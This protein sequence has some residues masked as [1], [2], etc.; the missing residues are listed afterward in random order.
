MFDFLVHGF[1]DLIGGLTHPGQP[2]KPAPAKTVAQPRQ[3]P[4]AQTR[5]GQFATP[6]VK[7][8]AMKTVQA[9][10]PK[11]PTMHPQQQK[12]APFDPVGFVRDAVVKPVVDSA[13]TVGNA[14]ASG[15]NYL[16]GELSG[17]HAQQQQQ[18][19]QKQAQLIHTPSPNIAQHSALLQQINQLKGQQQSQLADV[20]K[21]NDPLKVGAASVNLGA[22]VAA[23]GMSKIAEPV[24]KALSPFIRD[25][26]ANVVGHAVSQVPTGA[27]LGATGQV[28]QTGVHTTPSQLLNAALSGGA[29]GGLLGATGPLVS[30]TVKEIRH[31]D[32]HDQR[33]SIKIPNNK[34]VQ[35]NPNT[36]P[37]HVWPLAK[38]ANNYKTAHGFE[39]GALKQAEG[40]PDLQ[41][42]INEVGDLQSFHALTKASPKVSD[43]KIKGPAKNAK[44]QQFVVA[45]TLDNNGKPTYDLIP[46]DNRKHTLS[47]G[48][49]TDKKGKPVG[50]Y[51]GVD[52]HG[53]QFAYVEG[54]PVN[55]TGVLGDL[56]KWGNLNKSSHDMNRL[57]EAN[58]PDKATAT[59]VQNWITQFKDQQE[60]TMK[61]ELKQR[62]DDLMKVR[63][64]VLKAKPRG[65]SQKQLSEDLFRA[66]EKK[67]DMNQLRQKYGDD[68]IDKHFIPTL[69][70]SRKTY[71]DLLGSTNNVLQ[72]NGFDPIPERKNYI[73]HI[74]DEPGFWEKVGLGVQ[75]INPL[76]GSIDSDI[77]PGTARGGIPDEIVGNTANTGARRKFNQFAQERKGKSSRQDFFAAHDAYYEPMLMN[78][79]MTPAASRAR[80]VERAFRTN[81]KANELKMQEFAQIVGSDEAKK[82][83]GPKLKK[84]NPNYVPSR[85]SPLVTAWQEYGNQLAGKTNTRD[86]NIID[87]YGKGG[88]LYMNASTKFQ[89]LAGASTIPGSA[90]AALAQVLS[91]PQTFARDSFG[92]VLRG[93]K[94]MMQYAAGSKDDP[95]RQSAFMRARYTDASSQLR[96]KAQK[97]THAASKPMEMIERATGELSW[98]SAYNQAVK[99]GLTGEAAIKAA[100]IAAKKTLAGRGIGDR[101]V[102]MNSKADGW[103]T[104]FGLEVNNMR[105][106]FWNDFTPAQKIKFMVAAAALNYGYKSITGNSPLPDYIG[107][108]VQSAQDF[109]NSN[110]DKKD[111]PAD[112]SIQAGQRLLGETSKF[113]PGA[114]TLAS[115]L[116]SDTQRQQVFGK[117]GDISRYGTPPLAA[118]ITNA[119]N[120]IGSALGGDIGGAAAAFTK[121]LPTGNQIS[122]TAQGAAA[123]GQGY[124][125][126]KKG[127][128]QSVNEQT[129]PFTVPQ[130]LLFGKN[131]LPGQQQALNSGFSLPPKESTFFKG[132]YQENPQQATDYFNSALKA[133]IDKSNKSGSLSNLGQEP[134]A[135]AASG[136]SN[137]SQP[138][139]VNVVKSTGTSAKS[140]LD[141]FKAL[142]T[143]QH[144]AWSAAPNNDPEIT[145]SLTAWTG[146]KVPVQN[147]SNDLAKKW[148]QYQQDY[149]DGKVSPIIADQRKRSILKDAFSSQLDDTEKAISGL[150][151]A[152][153]TSYKDTGAITQPQLDKVIAVEKQQYDA[154]LIK[155][156][157]FANKLGLPARGYKVKK[158]STGR[159][160]GR[161]GRKATVKAPKFVKARSYKLPT[162][163]GHTGSSG[164]HKPNVHLSSALQTRTKKPSRKRIKA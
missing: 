152:A 41:H 106:Q 73:T 1:Q 57:I 19:L 128:V 34:S 47:N 93:A 134:T 116:M 146:G 76:G 103:L 16:G 56:N 21:Y 29:A 17:Q 51:L 140:L 125:T 160:K 32:F 49:V 111:T 71:G 35:Q 59:K 14:Y 3:A 98:R 157:T 129:N 110:D 60:A 50:S 58:A 154:G 131:S 145:K 33:G 87:N 5:V 24:T 12:Q 36:L 70:W 8:L 130:A 149:T 64:D 138:Q 31:T 147:I 141:Y 162:L 89:G 151:K 23:P 4:P 6:Q 144:K 43:V 137:P 40:N 97:Y 86:R 68:F 85:E 67:T 74:Q 100:D 48:M 53:Q 109:M 2:S 81:D 117:N 90:T 164:V 38:V 94:D 126:D 112:N 22:T 121:L 77:N 163:S 84:T 104:Q 132:Q 139:N 46:L 159:R 52:E 65:V 135:N 28:E 63:K 79:Y 113:I 37:Q 108:G 161:T 83:M 20:N 114:P 7:P 80:V 124:Q 142:P 123:L 25:G 88:K 118:P 158:A 42:Q 127:N 143:D 122:R 30:H 66:V 119:V 11:L 13:N 150:S 69:D 120:G 153:I 82:T 96:S 91:L 105:V 62:R 95:L 72:R 10:A 9:Q 136:P 101:P 156:E 75:N 115:L 92:S 18:I 15:I 78:K 55:I 45:N 61:T 102:L 133:K 155:Q 107:A 44:G 27:V 26:V 54:K 99:K 148:A 39:K